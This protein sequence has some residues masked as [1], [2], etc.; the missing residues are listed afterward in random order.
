MLMPEYSG[1]IR[2]PSS[3]PTLNCLYVI[4][5]RD[6]IIRDSRRLHIG[7]YGMFPRREAK[8]GGHQRDR[9]S[10]ATRHIKVSE[11]CHRIFLSLCP[12]LLHEFPELWGI[13]EG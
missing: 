2:R 5:A 9:F 4:E 13:A 11:G 7:F 8:G 10:H 3:E 1:E 6:N 12:A